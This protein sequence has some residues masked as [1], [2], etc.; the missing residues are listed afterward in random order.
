MTAVVYQA[1]YGK[2]YRLPTQA[3]IDA[4]EVSEKVLE[5]IADQIPYGMPNEPMP[6]PQTLGFT[7]PLYGFKKWSDLFTNRQL[8]ALMTFVRWTPRC[9]R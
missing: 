2:E 3:E 6:G 9:T 5:A 1:E 4:A 8:L 7:I